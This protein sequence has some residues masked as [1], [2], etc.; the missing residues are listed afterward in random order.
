MGCTTSKASPA[1]AEAENKAR[2][3]SEKINRQQQESMLRDAVAIK[4]L[5]LGAGDSGKTTL[6]K[7]MRNL[8]G[9]GFDESTRSEYVHVIIGGLVEGTKEI[10]TAMKT[11]FDV[12]IESD[13]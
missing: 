2:A 12:S 5:L 4:L 1:D 9:T 10:L 7:Q 13:P 6:R 11:Q 3:I 8:Y